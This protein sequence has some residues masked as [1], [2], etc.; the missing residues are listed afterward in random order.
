MIIAALGPG[1]SR[2]V[3]ID[4]GEVV[5]RRSVGG[6]AMGEGTSFREVP[7]RPDAFS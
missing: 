4:A 3:L 7:I 1:R 2:Q 6:V 5:S